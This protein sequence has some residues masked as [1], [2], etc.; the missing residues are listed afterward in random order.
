MNVLIL[1]TLDEQAEGL[2]HL[3]RIDSN[4]LYVFPSIPEGT[5]FHSMNVAE[6]FDIAFLTDWYFV[7]SVIRMTPTEDRI[8]APRGTAFAI[9]AK[10]GS[11]ARWGFVPG[12]QRPPIW[13]GRA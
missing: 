11:L 12:A 4:V 10:A 13:G 7:L 9:E 3:E 8:R 1:E 5:E 6:P 2:Q